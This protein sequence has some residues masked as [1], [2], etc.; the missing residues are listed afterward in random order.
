MNPRRRIPEV[1][2]TSTSIHLWRERG[3]GRLPM[4]KLALPL[5]QLKFARSSDCS[6]LIPLIPTATMEE[7]VD[8]LLQKIYEEEGKNE[9]NI[10]KWEFGTEW[11]QGYSNFGKKM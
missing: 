5:L 11:L 7:T 8:G 3:V 6:Y 2:P 10:C 4:V 9:D 1:N